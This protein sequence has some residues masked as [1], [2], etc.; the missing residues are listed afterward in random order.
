M[1]AVRFCIAWLLLTNQFLTAST[2]EK[3]L[4]QKAPDFTLPDLNGKAVQ[5]SQFQ[6]KV[7]VLVFW[8]FWC[9]TWKE[10][11]DILKTVQEK[12]SPSSVQVLCIA[13]DPSWKEVGRKMQRRANAS[14]PIL[15]DKGRRVSKLYG[16]TKVPT[17]L[18]LDKSGT[19]RLGFLGCPKL[20]LLEAAI[21][22]V[23]NIE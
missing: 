4:G 2:V 21:H 6:G 1:R 9:D 22:S 11:V 3:L 23:S 7:V 19:V 18:L 13:V 12:F 20:N 8:A 10:I 16:I 15:L 5:L 17:V 14:F